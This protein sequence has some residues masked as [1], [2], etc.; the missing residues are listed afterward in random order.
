MAVSKLSAKHLAIDRAN[1]QMVALVAIAAFVSI[2]SLVAAHAVWGQTRYQ[3]KVSGAKEKAH[4]Q[5]QKNLKAFDSLATSYRAFNATS[6]NVIGGTTG[7]TQDNDGSNAKLILDAL[8]SSYDFPALTS[9]IEK[10][11]TSQS[12]KVSAITGTDDQLNQQTNVESPTPQPVEM[13]FSFTVSNADYTS[14]GKLVD[15][16]N[17]SIRPM[18]IDS[19]AVNGGATNMTIVVNAHTYYQPAKN[20]SIVKKVVK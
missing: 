4:Q 19:I 20:V 11:L 2:F 18:Q 8:P 1:T 15:A 14:V 6:T 17:R 10:I 9:S 16:M 5:L 7:G 3:A 13:P 12:L